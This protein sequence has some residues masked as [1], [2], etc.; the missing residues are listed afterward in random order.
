MA[1]VFN[2]LS[3]GFSPV[4]VIEG[5]MSFSDFWSSTMTGCARSLQP[6]ITSVEPAIPG[7]IGYGYGF[8][9]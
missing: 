7:Q 9:A 6:T 5:R 8:D 1:G 4:D 3:I 2:G